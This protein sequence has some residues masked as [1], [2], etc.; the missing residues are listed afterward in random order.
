MLKE[1][2]KKC[3]AVTGTFCDNII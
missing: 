3:E 1:H 2:T